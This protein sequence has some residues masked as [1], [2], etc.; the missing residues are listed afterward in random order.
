MA[1]RKEGPKTWKYSM[2]FK[3]AEGQVL[4]SDN[5]Y[6][7]RPPTERRGLGLEK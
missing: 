4:Q 1:S 6:L 5:R 2:E 7:L 3:R